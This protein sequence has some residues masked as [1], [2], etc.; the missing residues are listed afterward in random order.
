MSFQVSDTPH[1]GPDY[2]AGHSAKRTRPNHKE[3][4]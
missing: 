3:I 2:I 1:D 4:A